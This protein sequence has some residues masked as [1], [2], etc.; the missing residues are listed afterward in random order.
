M[1]MRMIKSS[2][3]IEIIRQGARIAD[4]GGEAVK[5]VIREG[6]GE[7]EVALAGTDAMVREIAKTYPHLDLRDS[8]YSLSVSVC[9]SFMPWQRFEDPGYELAAG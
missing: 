2:E 8:K 5:K 6:V 4:L 7:H 9:L 3:E 1:R